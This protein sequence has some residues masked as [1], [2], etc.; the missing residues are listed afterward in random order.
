MLLSVERSRARMS[1]ELASG[2][3]DFVRCALGQGIAIK[4]A[5]PQCG[6]PELC[7]N[8][9][10]SKLLLFGLGCG[11]GF[12]FGRRGFRGSRL[13]GLAVFF[14]TLGT[15]FVALLALLVERGFTA[16][17]FHEGDIATITLAE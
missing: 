10:S 9:T 7:G 14:C 13:H 4:K 6:A 15:R 11:L 3:Q 1:S 16:E 8:G 17:Q 12:T 5:H 2:S